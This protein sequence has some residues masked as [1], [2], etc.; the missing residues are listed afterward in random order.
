MN[1]KFDLREHIVGYCSHAALNKSLFGKVDLGDDSYHSELL[2]QI[3]KT[4]YNKDIA[5]SIVKAK[6]EC[7]RSLSL[8]SIDTMRNRIGRITS[9]AQC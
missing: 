1:N 4:M 3:A 8:A 5:K 6:E 7:M 9:L 2:Y